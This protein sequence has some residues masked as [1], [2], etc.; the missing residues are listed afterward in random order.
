VKPELTDVAAEAVSSTGIRLTWRYHAAEPA[1]IEV[2]RGNWGEGGFESHTIAM[3]PAENGEF[4][5][6]GLDPFTYYY[7]A[8]RAITADDS[9]AWS[10]SVGARTHPGDDAPPVTVRMVLPRP[11]SARGEVHQDHRSAVGPEPEPLSRFRGIEEPQ[12]NDVPN[13]ELAEIVH[14]P[15]IDRPDEHP[16]LARA[17][18]PG[19]DLGAWLYPGGAEYRYRVI[20]IVLLRG[21]QLFLRQAV[22]LA[23]WSPVSMLGAGRAAC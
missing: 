6:Q 22:G 16:D 17:G 2:R 21:A 20:Q 4:T 3:E 11:R 7:Y 9:T 14:T 13:V 15:R 1:E 19:A 23:G 18:T 5:D 8:I 12:G 10:P